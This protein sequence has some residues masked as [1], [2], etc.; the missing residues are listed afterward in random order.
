MI[1]DLWGRYFIDLKEPTIS[2]RLADYILKDTVVK[3]L[4]V[5][6]EQ[7]VIIQLVSEFSQIK[8]I[9]F[10]SKHALIRNGIFSYIFCLFILSNSYILNHIERN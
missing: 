10:I 3:V 5:N 2:G 8:V 9:R 4:S 7:C 1:K 6:P